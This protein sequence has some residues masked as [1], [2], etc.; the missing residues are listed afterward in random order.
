MKT[1][2][3]NTNVYKAHTTKKESIFTKFWDAYQ[4]SL[5]EIICGY[6][7][8]NDI[9]NVYPIYRALNGNK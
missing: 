4:E 3:M 5:P 7:A 1:A 6:L 2:T 9:S 8:L